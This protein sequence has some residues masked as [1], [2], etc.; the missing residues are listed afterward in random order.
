[1]AREQDFITEVRASARKMW[2]SHN[3]LL[4][5]QREYSAMDFA[6]ELPDGEGDNADVTAAEISAVVVN[7][8]N[9]VTTMLGTGHATNLA[10][11]L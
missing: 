5:L 3:E 9:A 8:A 2:E 1:M 4:A 10:K 7:T 6:N 11:V